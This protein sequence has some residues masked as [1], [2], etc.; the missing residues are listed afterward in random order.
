MT[1]DVFKT[2]S[3]VK[4]NFTGVVKKQ[5]ILKMVDNCAKGQCDCMSSETKDKITG[6]EVN[7]KDGDISLNISGDLAKEEIENALAK[8]KVL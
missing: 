8:S 3:G 5:Q 6:M 4:I 7:G 1:K 2:D